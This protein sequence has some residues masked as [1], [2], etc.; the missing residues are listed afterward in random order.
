[1]FDYAKLILI[2]VS[3]N[4]FLFSHEL[5]KFVALLSKEENLRLKAWC[6]VMFGAMYAESIKEAF[7]AI[8]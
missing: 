2:K 4:P 6:I 8:S 7:S 5:K 3:F 1:M